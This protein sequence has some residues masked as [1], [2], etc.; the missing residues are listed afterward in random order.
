MSNMSKD[1]VRFTIPSCRLEKK[2]SGDR[3]RNIIQRAFGEC[4]GR[5]KWSDV[6][7]ICRPSQFARFLIYGEEAGLQNMF[8]ELKAE[9]FVPDDQKETVFDVSGN[10]SRK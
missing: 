4:L 2:V 5:C 9:F 8:A 1:R 6:T 3:M 10:P 7:I